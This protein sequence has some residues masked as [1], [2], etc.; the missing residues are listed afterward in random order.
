MFYNEAKHNILALL[1]KA[2]K[3]PTML[4]N[5]VCCPHGGGLGNGWMDGWMDEWVM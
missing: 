4:V 5:L 3:G 2:N 1:G